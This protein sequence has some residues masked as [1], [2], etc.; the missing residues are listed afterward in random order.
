[1]RVAI[2]WPGGDHR[3]VDRVEHGRGP[4]EDVHPVD[5]AVAGRYQLGGFDLSGTDGCVP[6]DDGPIVVAEH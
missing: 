1:V 3:L 2:S 4:Q 6:E 5:G